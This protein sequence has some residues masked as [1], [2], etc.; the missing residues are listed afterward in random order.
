MGPR[1]RF[2][3]WDSDYLQLEKPPVFVRHPTF[4]V[5][6]ASYSEPARMMIDAV[7]GRMEARTRDPEGAPQF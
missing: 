2:L 5:D 4:L 3:G 6:G 1:W 7:N